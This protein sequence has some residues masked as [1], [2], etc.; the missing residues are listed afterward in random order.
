VLLCSH[1]RRRLRSLILRNT[2]PVTSRRTGPVQLD[3]VR[4]GEKLL[5]GSWA[6]GQAVYRSALIAGHKVIGH[7]VSRHGPHLAVGMG[8]TSEEVLL[9]DDR[10]RDPAGDADL[11]GLGV[12][13]PRRGGVD[14]LRRGGRRRC[15]HGDRGGVCGRASR[16]RVESAR[17]PVGGG[18]R[19]RQRCGFAR[20]LRLGSRVDW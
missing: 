2:E 10:R 17:R 5:C 1:G 14:C 8:S 20:H 11:F 7:L 4:R 12:A 9:G 16:E 13:H 15:R 18:P 6:F 3:V 19:R